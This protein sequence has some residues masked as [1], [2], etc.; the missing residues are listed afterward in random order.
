MRTAY[1]GSSALKLARAHLPGLL[2]SDVVMPGMTGIELALSLELMV[3]EC[4]I[5]LFS[6]QAATVDLLDEA[7]RLGHDFTILN[8]PVHPNDLLRHVSEYVRPVREASHAM[9]N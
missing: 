2:I 9:V 4:R 5:L 1:D 6:G 8:K 3:P 7:R